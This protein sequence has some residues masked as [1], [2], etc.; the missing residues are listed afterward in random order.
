MCTRVVTLCLGVPF[1]L[2]HEQAHMAVLSGGEHVLTCALLRRTGVS[3]GTMLRRLSMEGAALAE[4][5]GGNRSDFVGHNDGGVT[6][7]AATNAPIPSFGNALERKVSAL[8]N[9][10]DEREDGDQR[11]AKAHTG[12]L[13]RMCSRNRGLLRSRCPHRHNWCKQPYQCRRER[14]NIC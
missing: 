9:G 3:A 11:P 8:F 13:P 2:L 7:G 10:F 6:G 14:I 4:A 5:A 12:P 1:D